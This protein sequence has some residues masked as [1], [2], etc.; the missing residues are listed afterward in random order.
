[1]SQSGV[2]FTFFKKTEPSKV[3][4]DSEASTN[5]EKKDFVLALEGKEIHR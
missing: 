5:E 3:K 4:K 2:S 1:M